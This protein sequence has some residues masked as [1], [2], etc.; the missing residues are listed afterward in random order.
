[1][2]PME[3]LKVT[4]ISRNANRT[5]ILMRMWASGRK[6]LLYLEYLDLGYF[7]VTLGS[8]V[9]LRFIGTFTSFFQ[10]LNYSYSYQYFDSNRFPY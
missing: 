2:W 9:R 7:K 5:A 1:M 6:C 3:K 4:N 8:L 10:K